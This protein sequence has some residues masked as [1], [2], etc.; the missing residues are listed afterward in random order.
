MKSESDRNHQTGVFG[1]AYTAWPPF[2]TLPAGKYVTA[3]S[4]QTQAP[5]AENVQHLDFLKLDSKD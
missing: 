4:L 5:A 2:Q 1:R 3:A